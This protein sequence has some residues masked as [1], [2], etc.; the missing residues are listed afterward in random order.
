MGQAGQLVAVLRRTR[1]R[2]DLPDMT[3]LPGDDAVSP[4]LSA[5]A[6]LIRSLVRSI[7]APPPG[8]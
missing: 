8:R 5:I 4:P 7:W 1:D 6:R 2:A 3:A